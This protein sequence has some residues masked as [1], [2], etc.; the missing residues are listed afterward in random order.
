MKTLVTKA[1]ATFAAARSGATVIEYCLIAG[2]I[3]LAIIGAV[4]SLGQ[5]TNENFVAVQAG[6][7]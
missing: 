2:C 3:A 6:W 4:S 5:A 7:N 1:L